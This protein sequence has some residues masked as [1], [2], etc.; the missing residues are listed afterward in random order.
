MCKARTAVL[1]IGLVLA[2]GTFGVCYGDTPAAAPADQGTQTTA[3]GDPLDALNLNRSELPRQTE[4]LWR[5]VLAIVFVIVL[6]VAAFY[7]SRRLGPRLAMGRGREVCV[8]ET[9]PLGPNRHLHLVRAG[10]DRRLLI[11]VTPQNIRLVADVTDTL[12]DWKE[13]KA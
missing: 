11:G 8:L 12:A 10:K 13:D 4:L 3:A 6:G 7:V 2:A 5:F 1:Y 9:I